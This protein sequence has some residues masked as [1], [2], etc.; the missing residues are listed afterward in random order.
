MRALKLPVALAAV[1]AAVLAAGAAPAGAS[2]TRVAGKIVTFQDSVGE[3]TQELDVTTVT[4]SS[5]AG[6]LLTFKVKVTNHPK[7]TGHMNIRVELD[8][9]RNPNNGCGPSC[10][11]SDMILD[12]IPGSIAVG[13]WKGSKWDFSA[14]SPASLV[15]SYLNGTATIAVKASDLK[16]TKFNFWILSDTNSSDAHSHVDY[17]PDAGHGTWSYAVSK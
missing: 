1:A 9:D 6:G 15:Y 3:N 11:G 5:D 12:L 8:S 13:R 14:K 4:V 17:A 7:L 2:P 16:L 10:D